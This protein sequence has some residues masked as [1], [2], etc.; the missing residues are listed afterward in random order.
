MTSPASQDGK[1][2]TVFTSLLK[3]EYTHTHTHTHT[4]TPAPPP[5]T[6]TTITIFKKLDLRQQ[7]TVIFGRRET[8]VVSRNIAT[9]YC[10]EKVSRLWQRKGD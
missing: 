10:P 2:E 4:H 3:Q 7:K 1:T 8:N 9:T 5:P 6:T